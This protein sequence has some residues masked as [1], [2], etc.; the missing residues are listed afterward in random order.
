MRLLLSLV[1]IFL[2]SSQATAQ[3]Q[4]AAKFS[5]RLHTHAAD[6]LPYRLFVPDAL[7]TTARY[8]LVLALHGAGERGDDNN[9]H[10]IAYRI[11]T[12][13]ADP[14]NQAKYPCLVAAPQAAYETSWTDYLPVL[15][16]LLDS[17]AREFPVDTN[18]LY[19]TGLSMGGFGTFEMITDLPEPLCRSNSDELGLESRR[20][21]DHLPPADLDVSWDAR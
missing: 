1:T 8:P 2:L 10:I 11:A 14:V 5:Y 6:S 20:C 4:I 12:A 17:L 19:I 16:D 3:P 18:R 21:A 13:W 9:T 15:S 7:D